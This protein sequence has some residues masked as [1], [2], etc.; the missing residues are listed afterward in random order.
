MAGSAGAVDGRRTRD[1]QFS[2]A[3]CHFPPSG[4]VASVCHQIEILFRMIDGSSF[5]TSSDDRKGLVGVGAVDLD[6]YL[7]VDPETLTQ[8]LY[9]SIFGLGRHLSET[10]PHVVYAAG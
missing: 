5:S 4:P 2:A 9:I 8:N 3:A 6:V 1:F 7:Q 10:F